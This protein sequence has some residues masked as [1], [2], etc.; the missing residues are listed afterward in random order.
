MQISAILVKF[1]LIKEH[2][3]MAKFNPLIGIT[4]KLGNLSFYVDKHGKQIVRTINKPKDPKT[5]KQQAHR[6]KFA[7]ANKAMSP[8]CTTIKNANNGDST[9]YRKLVG[10]AYKKAIIGEY[11]DFAFDYS[12]IVI[13][14]GTLSLPANINAFANDDR[15]I[16]IFSWESNK[17]RDFLNIVCFNENDTNNSVYTERK[18]LSAGKAEIDLPDNWESDVIHCWIYMSSW[19]FKNYSDSYYLDI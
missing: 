7:L 4:G 5:L 11:P 3:T 12:K 9:Y 13:V 17:S 15:S 10:E 14:N 6:A 19:D 8:M 2:E 18:K 16:L 1:T